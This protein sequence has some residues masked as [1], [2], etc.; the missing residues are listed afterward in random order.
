[1]P[2]T[3]WTST[4]D[5][6][7]ARSSDRNT[8]ASRRCSAIS[9]RTS[10]WT[11]ATCRTPT[12]GG[13]T[14]T[15]SRTRGARST[16][17]GL[18]RSPTRGAAR[19]MARASGA[20]RRAT[21]RATSRST[22]RRARALSRLCSARHRRRGC[23]RRLHARADG[24]GGVDTVRAGTRDP[25]RAQH[26]SALRHATSTAIRISR[27]IQPE[28]QFR[29]EPLAMVAASRSSAGSTSDYL[30]IDQGAIVAMIENYRSDIDL[31]RDAH[32]SPTSAAGWSARASR[33]LAHRLTR[34]DAGGRP[35]RWREAR[36][37]WRLRAAIA[38]K[39]VLPLAALRRSPRCASGRWGARAKSSRQLLPD[40]ERS[41][42]G[43]RVDV[44]QL[45]W[46]AAHEKLLTAFAGDAT[47][48]ICQLG[49]TWVPEFV[50]ARCARA[51]G[52]RRRRLAGSTPHDYF[53]GIW[54]TNVI[55]G[56]LYGVPWYVDTR[57]LFYRRDLLAPA[58]YAAPPRI[59]ED[60]TRMMAAIKA[61]CRRRGTMRSCC[62][63]TNSSRCSHSRC[64]R[65]T[66]CCA[67]A[68]AT[69]QFC[70]RRFPSR[71]RS[72]TSSMFRQRLRAT[73]ERR[74]QMSN[75]WNEFG[76]G[77]FAFYISGSVEHRRVRASPAAGRAGRV[78]H[79]AL[80]RTQR[81]GRV[82]RRRLEPGAVPTS[83]VK[84][85][86]R[87]NS[88]NTLSRP[89]S[90]CASTSLTGDLPPRRSAVDDQAPL[91]DDIH[92]RAFRDQLERAKPAPKVPEWERIAD[93]MRLVAERAARGAMDHRSI[94]GAAS[95]TRA[96]THPRKAALDPR[97][98]RARRSGVEVSRSRAA[99]VVCSRP[100]AARHRRV[101]LLSGHC[102]AC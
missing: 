9:I 62:R 60:W 52:P 38:A 25:G 88:S 45:P 69:G 102:R 37:H 34:S 46:T 50:G 18:M 76:R 16:R 73:G 39:P 17:S 13:G 7:G 31:E 12:C 72:S 86:R 20:S 67:T 91:A 41:H 29:D 27:C 8:W 57:L 61:A 36:A 1:M 15:I 74:R 33:G 2:G 75:V 19:T 40:F 56:T 71:A 10:G 77:Y 80:A 98:Q 51:A 99:C 44:Q 96:P 47:P 26:V 23:P 90:S 21:A 6:R 64:S 83:K 35:R 24:R 85:A 65:T 66:R 94:S 68:V 59:W 30:G 4:Y 42:P 53:A 84:K 28:L 87:G 54:E 70:Q 11:S 22:T 79:R 89:T 3:Q 32:E 55:G 63:S 48:D 95:S 101:L 78:G 49:N 100:G 5:Q 14:S 81:A 43:I 58:G 93:E 92:A 97:A 82:D